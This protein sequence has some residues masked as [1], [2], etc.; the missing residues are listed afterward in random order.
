M[1]HSFITLHPVIIVVI[2]LITI[3]LVI[4]PSIIVYFFKV[5]PYNRG[6]YC[7][8]QSIRY[9][10]K[11]DT[12]ST[13]VL[14]L[15][16][17]GIPLLVIMFTEIYY[18]R[19]RLNYKSTSYPNIPEVVINI[20]IFW[21]IFTFGAGFDQML[22]N[23]SKFLIGR[24]RPAFIQGC[25][26]NF[27]KINCSNYNYV[28]IDDSFCLRKDPKILQDIRLSFPSGHSSLAAYCA[29]ALSIYLLKRWKLRNPF[30][31]VRSL[32][33]VIFIG[34][35][36]MCGLSRVSDYKHHWSDVLAGLTSGTMEAIIVW[37]IFLYVDETRD[38]ENNLELSVDAE[39]IAK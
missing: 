6:F 21:G 33:Q 36:V 15:V 3:F 12:I 14:L 29:V 22:T 38:L 8:D 35:A 5:N 39:K 32:V 10:F 28:I 34:L 9:P 23:C 26:V 17:I 25:Q 18:K 2:H 1:V 37:C 27:S 11:S 7:D 4:F 20:Y 13:S 24:L 30:V 31:I 19:G 16:G